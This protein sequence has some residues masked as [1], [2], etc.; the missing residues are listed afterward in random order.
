[1]E[2]RPQRTDL[3]RRRYFRRR[4][5]G[6]MD[7]LRPQWPD[8]KFYSNIFDLKIGTDERN[9][10]LVLMIQNRTAPGNKIGHQYGCKQI[11]AGGHQK[12]QIV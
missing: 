1:M 3:V 10:S 2:T 7:R 11:K 4:R 9:L 5:H 8:S 6:L 12:D